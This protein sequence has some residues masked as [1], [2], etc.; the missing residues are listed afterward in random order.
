MNEL[1]TILLDQINKFM[2]G[3]RNIDDSC[4]PLLKDFLSWNPQITI[5]G[6]EGLHVG[7]L[8]FLITLLFE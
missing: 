2:L 6:V 4:I 8:D 7:E 3:C 5:F 1:D